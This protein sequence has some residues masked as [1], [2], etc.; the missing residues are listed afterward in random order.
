[1]LR[2]SRGPKFSVF[3]LPSS[4]VLQAANTTPPPL[5]GWVCV[6]FAAAAAMEFFIS[7]F[8]IFSASQDWLVC[9]SLCQFQMVRIDTANLSATCCSFWRVKEPPNSR[10]AVRKAAFSNFL[11]RP[12]L[13]VVTAPFQGFG[14]YGHCS[15]EFR[16]PLPSQ[17]C[18]CPS[19][20]DGIGLDAD[21]VRPAVSLWT[22]WAKS[23]GTP[24]ATCTAPLSS[25]LAMCALRIRLLD[26]AA[27]GWLRP[28]PS[29]SFRK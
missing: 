21:M 3:W 9:S 25:W 2:E 7:F 24:C 10:K 22:L 4:R 20:Q 29:P 28:A 11:G 5:R 15:S 12:R 14:G 6:L 27:P 8:G 17:H 16:D 23:S 19:A 13:P 1:M 26:S 18:R